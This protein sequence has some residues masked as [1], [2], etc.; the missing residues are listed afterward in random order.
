M[1]RGLW[2]RVLVLGLVAVAASLL[3]LTAAHA[4]DDDAALVSLASVSNGCGGGVAGEDARFF[5]TLDYQ[6]VKVSFREACNVHDACYSGAVVRD[7]FGR[8]PG[9]VVDFRDWSRQRCDDVFLDNLQ[10]L[11]RRQIHD[12]PTFAKFE[13]ARNDRE[14]GH[15][16]VLPPCTSLFDSMPT[17]VGNYA[18]GAE[19]AHRVV[20]KCGYLFFRDRRNLSGTW[21]NRQSSGT[22][23]RSATIR[24]VGRDVTVTWTGAS[25]ACAG[26]APARSSRATRPTRSSATRRSRASRTAARSADRCAS[27]RRTTRSSSRACRAAR[28]SIAP[29]ARRSPRTRSALRRSRRPRRSRSPRPAPSC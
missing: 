17:L 24:Q 18:I 21:T 3:A 11:C 5:D 10:A 8:P 16:P 22:S 1:R 20:R 25:R 27:W 2:I 9:T 13:Q 7:P 29:G 23:V 12:S 14:H 19:L 26:A 28:R 6:G 15:G 4:A